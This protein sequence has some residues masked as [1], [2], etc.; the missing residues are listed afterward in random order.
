MIEFF[1]PGIPKPGGS[2]RAFRNRKTG[3]IIITEDCKGNKDWRACVKMFARESYS[4]PPLNGPLKVW[5]TF[6][7]PRPKGHYGTGKNEGTLKPS[8]P[9]YPTTTPDATK[10][11]RSTEDALTGILWRDD[12]Q[13][14]T[15]II[16]KE[17]ADYC[18]DHFQEP[19]VK[20]AAQASVEET[21]KRLEA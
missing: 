5:A 16:S 6:Y 3:G 12:A 9:E 17:Y 21:R 4:G 15:Q 20:I 8:A 18:F 14:V 10:L 11:W 2:K 19:G 13:I 7:M 1:V